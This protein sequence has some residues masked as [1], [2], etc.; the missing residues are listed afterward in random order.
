MDYIGISNIKTISVDQIF[1]VHYFEYSNDFSFPGETHN[2]WEFLCVDK[3]EV[4]VVAAGEQLA[5][6]TNDLI[7]HEPNEFHAVHANGTCAPNLVVISFSC[8]GEI[9]DFFRSFK[10]FTI[11]QTGRNLLGKIISE[12]KR[13]FNCRLD[14][15]YLKAIVL[16]KPDRIGAEQLMFAYLEQFLLHLLRKHSPYPTQSN[17]PLFFDAVS[18][19]QV[20]DMRCFQTVVAFLNS[21]LQSKVTIEQ[22]CK[23]H[24]ISRS[25]LSKI[26]K[27]NCS[28]SIMEYFSYL[29]IQTAKDLIRTQ[30]M[31]FTQISEYLRYSSI[32][33]FSRQFKAITGMTPSEYA[34]SIKAIS[35]DGSNEFHT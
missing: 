26:F 19:R 12:A 20:A 13:C 1:S 9:M 10:Q 30:T 18:S 5:L 23:V 16:K 25:Y 3:G 8:R 17:A 33:Y 27:Q 21:N 2:F 22:I 32:H 34:S 29:K 28:L 24:N 6:K 7:F 4:N 14:D 35:E 11:D 15:P 31:N